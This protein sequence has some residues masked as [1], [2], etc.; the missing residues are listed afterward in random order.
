MLIAPAD[1]RYI[2]RENR[3]A[4]LYCKDGSYVLNSA[5]DELELILGEYGLFRCHQSYLVA[6]SCITGIQKS[7][8]GKTYLAILADG[9]KV[10]V[11]RQRYGALKQ[12][13]LQDGVPFL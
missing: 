9:T 1:M 5:L 8:F 2:V 6:L 4:K 12:R 11:S 3:K 7:E 10:P 13:L